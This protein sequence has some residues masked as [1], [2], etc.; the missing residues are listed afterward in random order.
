[1]PPLKD[2]LAV[3]LLPE[4]IPASCILLVTAV[5]LGFLRLYLGILCRCISLLLV[6]NL[7]ESVELFSVQLIEL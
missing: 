3:L 6:R 4:Y 5:C 7:L 2:N 1:M